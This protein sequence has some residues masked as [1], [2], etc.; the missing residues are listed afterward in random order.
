MIVAVDIVPKKRIDFNI[1]I[2]VSVY[3]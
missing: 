2:S 1:G 3:R